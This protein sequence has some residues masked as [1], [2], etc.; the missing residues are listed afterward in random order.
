MNVILPFVQIVIGFGIINVWV[1][2]YQEATAWRGGAASNMREE[3][4]VYGLPDWFMLAVGMLKVAL[5]TVLIA[6]IW[7]PDLARVAAGGMAV[8]MAGAVAMHLKVGDPP[9]KALPALAMLVLCLL[10]VIG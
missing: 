6:G 7:F 8:L 3:F 5:A 2:R 1:L 4:A 9:R 10:V